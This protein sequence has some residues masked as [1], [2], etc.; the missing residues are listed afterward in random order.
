MTSSTDGTTWTAQSPGFSTTVINCVAHGD[1]LFIA[2]ADAGKLRTSP[3]SG[4]ASVVFLP[5]TYSTEP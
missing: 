1:G 4:T 2:G 3:W 5:I